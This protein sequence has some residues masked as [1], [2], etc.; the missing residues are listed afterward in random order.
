LAGIR[1]HFN[2]HL[3][4]NKQF[5]A[6]RVS[7]WLAGKAAAFAREVCAAAPLI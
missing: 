6:S 1:F 3:A 2:R 7:T 5:P 4:A